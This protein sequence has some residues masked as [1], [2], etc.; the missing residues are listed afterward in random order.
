MRSSM[1]S[2]R[3]RLLES[4]TLRNRLGVALPELAS[5]LRFEVNG[6]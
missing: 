6:R 4:E 5:L 3:L 2:S 1:P